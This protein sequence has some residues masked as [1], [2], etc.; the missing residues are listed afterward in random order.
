MN[1][2]NREKEIKFTKNYTKENWET[3]YPQM[4]LILELVPPEAKPELQDFWISTLNSKL[5]DT[6]K[7][8]MIASSFSKYTADVKNFPKVKA[9]KFVK[10]V[11]IL[12]AKQKAKK[13]K[14]LFCGTPKE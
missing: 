10:N 14:G 12:K 11:A 9:L 6:E 2:K 7:T 3:D 1:M 8:K 4:D 13:L 5:T